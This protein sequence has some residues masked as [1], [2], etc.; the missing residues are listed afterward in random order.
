MTEQSDSNEQGDQVRPVAFIGLG[1]M[2]ASIADKL[3]DWPGGLRVCDVNPD[4]L[5][6]FT[7]KGATGFASAG[8][9]ARGAAV[10]SIVVLNDQQVRSV[11]EDILASRGESDAPQV[12]AIHSTIHP[13]TA[14]DLAE[15]CAAQGVLLVDAP[16]SGGAVAAKE[17]RLAVMIG[18]T[19]E[20]FAAV[21]EPFGTFAELVIHAGP[22]GSGT[23]MKLAR[24]LLHF[25]SFT[26]VTESQRL[27]EAAGVSLVDL[28]KVVR[29]TDS[30]S[31]GAGA[32]MLRDTTAPIAPD[33]FWHG[34]FTHVRN[35]GEKDL[36][37]AL[38]LGDELAVGLPLTAL[39]YDNLG[40]GLGVGA[41]HDE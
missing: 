7:D 14:I 16:V 25:I 32:I 36:S 40:I 21:S 28:G 2:G 35:L 26:A 30:I 11:V 8:E 20:A 24:N 18:G 41:G 4:A 6:P 37:L 12:I 9:A 29:H 33:D 34:V 13:Q 19:D 38:A 3:V 23:K 22:V 5:T 39:A 10:V 17:G 1:M 27:A 31:G 15:L